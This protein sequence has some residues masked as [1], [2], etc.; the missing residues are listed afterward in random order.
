MN[1]YLLFLLIL[2]FNIIQAQGIVDAQGALV[3]S[4]TLKKTIYLCFSGHDTYDG[5]PHVLHVLKK[6]NVKA[7]FFLT[8][9]FIREQTALTKRIINAG[10]YVGAHSNNHLL[11]CDWT[12]RDSLLQSPNTI[13]QDISK[14]ISALKTFGVTP[15]YFM[16]PYEWYNKKVVALAKELNQITINF[17]TGTL[18]NADYTTPDMPNYRSSKTILKSIFNYEKN[19]GMNGF[20]L[21]IH[22]GTSPLRKDKLYLHLNSLITKLKK[23][24]YQFKRF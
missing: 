7:S 9:D 16:P 10:H 11:Y 5:F 3:R 14:N 12:K 19:H 20:H 21:L 24:G 4:D 22:P 13:K 23:R 8:G 1:K 17:S 6:Q 2:P 18:S 15:R